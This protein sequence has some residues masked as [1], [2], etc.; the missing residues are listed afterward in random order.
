MKFSR[1]CLSSPWLLQPIPTQLAEKVELLAQLATQL[2]W[3]LGYH[4]GKS[5]GY[6]VHLPAARFLNVHHGKMKGCRLQLFL[7]KH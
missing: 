6:F 4:A 2:L 3:Q 7:S 5:C 1:S